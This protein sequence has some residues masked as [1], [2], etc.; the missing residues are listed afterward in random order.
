MVKYQQAAAAA[1]TTAALLPF[2]MWRENVA[3]A[4]MVPTHEGYITL[5]VMQR[6]TNAVELQKRDQ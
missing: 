3:V 5:H 6:P 1:T 4:N 2:E